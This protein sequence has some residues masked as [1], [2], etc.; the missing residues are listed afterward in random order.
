MGTQISS[1]LNGKKVGLEDLAGKTLAVDAYNMLYQFL[2]T[3]RMRDGTPL[4]NSKG[5]VTSH[6]VGLFNRLTTLM[7]HRIKFVFVYDGEAP[8]LKR[9]EREKRKQAKQEAQDAYDEAVQEEDV[10]SMK[11]YAGRTARL[12][13]E[14]ITQSQQVLEVL[15][16]PWIQAP[17]EAEAQAAQVVRNGDA[18]YV[19]S[20]DMDCL[21]FG[22]PHM[23]RNLSISGKRRRRGS[24]AYTKVHPE[25]IDLQALLEKLG[26]K[27]DQ[28]IALGMLVGTDFNPGGVKGLGPKRGLKLVEEKGDDLEAI[29]AEADW[30][31]H[32]EHD[33]KDIY[34]VIKE[35][36]V[37]DEY[38]IAFKD[39][40]L[41]QAHEVLV[42]EFEFSAKR[43]DNALSELQATT[44][45]KG[46]DDFF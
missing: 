37:T 22:A 29:F 43:V 30:D 12:T 26:I 14:M 39:V 32:N 2:T 13:E 27:Q 45:Q 9:A 5:H 38:E 33:W 42:D 24:Y 35:M 41:A 19:A 40:D 46:L 25:I 4:K 8:K 20:Q 34:R 31:V 17:S 15:G 16:I 18:D 21:L 28:L 7:Q 1:L 6:L 36:P 3:I 23:V 44:A 10:E 11:K